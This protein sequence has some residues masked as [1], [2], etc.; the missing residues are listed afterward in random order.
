MKGIRLPDS[1]LKFF[2]F[3]K[4]YIKQLKNPGINKTI[5]YNHCHC[6]MV[7]YGEREDLN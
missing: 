6:L 5:S 3:E 7:F 1:L 4:K 2:F